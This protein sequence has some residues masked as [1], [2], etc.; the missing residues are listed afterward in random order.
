MYLKDAEIQSLTSSCILMPDWMIFILFTTLDRNSQNSI[1]RL[2][3][4]N[5]TLGFLAPLKS[6]NNY[7]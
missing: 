1:Q 3:W 2:K 7:G 4:L 5:E 6:W